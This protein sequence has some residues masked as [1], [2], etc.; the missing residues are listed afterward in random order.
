MKA[1]AKFD[2]HIDPI[3]IGV[4]FTQAAELKDYPR[5]L[6]KIDHKKWK[7]FFIDY[8]KSLKK[9]IFK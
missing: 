1:K 9:Q 7:L 5:M 8:A 2:W 4:A 6:K 3:Q